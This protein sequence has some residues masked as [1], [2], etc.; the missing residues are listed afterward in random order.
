MNIIKQP[1][2]IVKVIIFLFT[3][4]TSNAQSTDMELKVVMRSIG[5]KV[6]WALGDSTS[7]VLPIKVSDEGD[8]YT[9]S[10]DKS[11]NINSDSLYDIVTKELKRAQ[12]FNF[13]AELKQCQTNDVVLAFIHYNPNDS[14]QPC[15]GRE[16]PFDCYQIVISVAQGTS[17]IKTYLGLLFVTIL[18][19]TFY[20]QRKK[21]KSNSKNEPLLESK[22][23]EKITIGQFTFLIF[24]QQLVRDGVIIDMTEKE[25]KLLRLF[26]MSINQVLSR[27]QLMAEIW[28][29][30]GVMVISRN[31]DVLVSKLRKKLSTDESIKITNVHGVGYRLEVG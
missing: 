1:I 18:G 17:N 25:V 26:L 10:F 19:L 12:V 14:I 6:L 4:I 2:L 23:M 24:E 15:R 20:Y 30:S 21:I 11:I 22:S 28:G 31:I 9:I 3:I 16:T 7:R 5:N 27:E 29:E 8:I 13:V